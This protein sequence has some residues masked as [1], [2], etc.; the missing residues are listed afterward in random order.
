MDKIFIYIERLKHIAYIGLLH[1]DIGNHLYGYITARLAPALVMQQT[2]LAA[3]EYAHS[4]NV[5][6]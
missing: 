4:N 1:I 3:L 5:P 2:A 6:C